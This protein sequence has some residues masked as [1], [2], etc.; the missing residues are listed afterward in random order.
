MRTNSYLNA[1]AILL[2]GFIFLS[3]TSSPSQA[4][5]MN[6]SLGSGSSVPGSTV[7]LDLSLTTSGVRS[8]R[9]FNGP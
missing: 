8:Q 5:Q 4:Q 3:I 9:L 6:V 1:L 7:E 2:I